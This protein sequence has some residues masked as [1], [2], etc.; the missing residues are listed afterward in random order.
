MSYGLTRR[1]EMLPLIEA[2][3]YIFKLT[4]NRITKDFI[5]SFLLGFISSFLHP[6]F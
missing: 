4:A 6:H 1:F 2:P 3:R 5:S